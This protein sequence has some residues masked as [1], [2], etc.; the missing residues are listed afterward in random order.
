[1]VE[2]VNLTGEWIGHYHFDEVIRIEQTGER[3][4]AVKVTG[5]EYVPAGAV[6]WR[7]DLRT[8]QGEGQ[9]AEKD[10]QHPRFVPGRLIV[11]NPE[12]IIFRWDKCGEVEYRKDE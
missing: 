7:A 5:D 6:T 4:E 10:F 1:V 2:I 12:R 3:I 8:L 11:V 9:I